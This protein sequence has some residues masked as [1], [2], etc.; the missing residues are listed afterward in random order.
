[1]INSILALSLSLIVISI[2]FYGSLK[3]YIKNIFRDKSKPNYYVRNNNYF[4]RN[5]SVVFWDIENKKWLC[6]LTYTWEF[7]FL[8]GDQKKYYT[9][10]LPL[11]SDVEIERI[12]NLYKNNIPLLREH[13]L[14]I[15]IRVKNKNEAEK[16]K[17]NINNERLNKIKNKYY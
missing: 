17:A 6:P 16:T 10:E 1:M 13:I 9:Y 11:D 5:F 4:N 12:I 8:T 15:K 3:K 2:I 14:D 7:A